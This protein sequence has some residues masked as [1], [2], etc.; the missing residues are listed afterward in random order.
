MDDMRARMERDVMQYRAIEEQMGMIEQ[1]IAM[2]EE[3]IETTNATLETLKFMDS[4]KGES[5]I[6]IPMGPGINLPVRTSGKEKLI[7]NI[8]AG[9]SVDM[10]PSRAA[11]IIQDKLD[12]LDSTKDKLASAYRD[13]GSKKMALEETIGREYSGAVGSDDQD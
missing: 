12:E 7:V 13:L 1:Q 11:A 5:E 2:V 9:V 3:T 8:G 10:E 4:M 6:L